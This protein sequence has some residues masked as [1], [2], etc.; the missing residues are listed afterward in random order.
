M[1]GLFAGVSILASQSAANLLA[2]AGDLFDLGSSL[3]IGYQALGGGNAVVG[4]I[5]TYVFFGYL[6]YAYTPELY[7]GKFGDIVEA[8]VF[9]A[10]T[11][12]A[13]LY[14][15]LLIGRITGSV[16]D[17]GP[18]V[19]LPQDDGNIMAAFLAGFV[20]STVIFSGYIHLLRDES[21]FDTSGDIFKTFDL[22][23][24]RPLHE[25]VEKIEKLPRRRRHL[26][27]ALNE[28]LVGAL[29]VTPAVFLGI[30][31]AAV[32]LLSPIPEGLVVVAVLGNYNPLSGRLPGSVADT[33]GSDIDFRIADNVMDS[34]QNRK[35][36]VL[37]WPCILGMLVSGLTLVFSI[38]IFAY[39]GKLFFDTWLG[40][41][42]IPDVLGDQFFSRIGG[43]V[44]RLW[45]GVG[46][47]MSLM[48]YVVYS[49]LYWFRQLQRLPAYVTF[50][51][52]HWQNESSSPPVPSVTRPP[53]LFLPGNALLLGLGL[54]AWLTVNGGPLIGW[55]GFGVV[56][57]VLVG[58]V[59]WSVRA[60]Y[61]HSPQPLRGEGRAILAAFGIQF[62]SFSIVF[63]L[64]TQ[65]SP[66]LI[67]GFPL[68]LVSLTYL[69]EFIVYSERR[70]GMAHYLDLIYATG[71]LAVSLFAVESLRSLPL[72][73]YLIVAGILL[74]WMLQKIIEPS[75]ADSSAG[76]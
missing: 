19:Y 48:T 69:P 4:A 53:G 26:Y 49:L 44:G 52:A 30:T 41:V 61:R 25:E 63:T 40:F 23:S 22:F 18:F 2:S 54:V 42:A 47:I 3:F 62:V 11:A 59:V 55:I 28:S 29:Y 24:T 31:L 34:F 51:Q 16:P 13:T 57:P 14:F 15:G 50:W 64:F 17:G 67:L 58:I 46:V 68:L 10:L 71:I 38:F 45:V 39:I 65:Q 12:V 20:V 1:A 7:I 21:L 8:Q 37:L 70:Q 56:W 6:V 36:M 43:L 35:G 32:G 9:R 75:P 74:V 60:G 73:V 66:W 5:L 27:V 72:V 76:E 33:V